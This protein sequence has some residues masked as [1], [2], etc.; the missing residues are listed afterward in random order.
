MPFSRFVSQSPVRPDDV[1]YNEHVHF[2][3]YLD[4]FMAARNDQMARCYKFPMKEYF[5]NGWNWLVRTMNIEYKRPLAMDDIATVRT[6]IDS[7]GDPA[8]GKRARSICSV[9]FEIEIGDTGKVAARGMGVFV[10]VSSE[11]GLPVDIPDW[12]IERH[13]I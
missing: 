4:Y 6:W 11:T 10:L 2:T 1:D 13:R 7:M 5:E 9:G 12:V 8:G 3:R